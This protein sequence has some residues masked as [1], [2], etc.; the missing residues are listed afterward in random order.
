MPRTLLICCHTPSPNMVQLADALSQGAQSADCDVIVRCQPPLQ[1]TADDVLNADAYLLGTT[2]NF[3]YM[4]GALK[5]FFDRINYP[6]LEHT[7]G[8][9]YALMVRAGLDGTGTITAVERIVS[10][11]RWNAIQ[12]PL[13]C[14]GDFQSTFVTQCEELG[15]LLSA[16]VDAGIW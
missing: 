11:L 1:T 6:C 3:G 16:G 4:S 15:Q 12:P 2:E 14:Q 8:R 9:P 5:D 13:L 7:Q 10:G